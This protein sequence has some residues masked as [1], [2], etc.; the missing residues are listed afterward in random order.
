M[1]EEEGSPEW[2]SLSFREIH[3]DI[4]NQVIH[5]SVRETQQVNSSFLRHCLH[6]PS[7]HLHGEATSFIV[8]LQ[9][10]KES[11]HSSSQLIGSQCFLDARDS[12]RL[13]LLSGEAADLGRLVLAVAKETLHS[14]FHVLLLDEPLQHHQPERS[15]EQWT[16]KGDSSGSSE[17]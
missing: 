9:A 16:D 6:S 4:R 1:S 2:S 11:S 12:H 7:H 5:G 17:R 15:V 3:D 10:L 8:S 13:Q 14:G